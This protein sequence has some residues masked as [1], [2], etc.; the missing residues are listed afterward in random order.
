MRIV[1]RSVG[2]VPLKFLTTVIS[3]MESDCVMA[4]I[5]NSESIAISGHPTARLSHLGKGR[6]R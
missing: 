3:D 2:Y 4:P 6:T 5:A 1:E